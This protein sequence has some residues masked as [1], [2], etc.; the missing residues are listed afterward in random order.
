MPVKPSPQKH[1]SEDLGDKLVISI[2]DSRLREELVLLSWF[3]LIVLIGTGLYIGVKIFDTPSPI[4]R[5]LAF[6]AILLLAVFGIPIY[7]FLRRDPTS[8]E[9]IETTAQNVKVGRIVFG[10]RSQKDFLAEHI[11]GLRVSSS[12]VSPSL[13]LWLYYYF[14]L[15]DR[16]Q[17]GSLVFDYGAQTFRFGT[18]IDEAEAKQIVEEIQQ[19]F[20][21]YKN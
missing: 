10:R 11:K 12:N 13:V 5:M 6:L 19:K 2:P 17:V 1:I 9:F 4:I 18:S 15:P 20:P 3:W 14:S 8:K 21:Q 16:L 7:R